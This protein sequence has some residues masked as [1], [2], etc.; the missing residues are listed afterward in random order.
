M[1][2]SER[3]DDDPAPQWISVK[4]LVLPA[5]LQI[6]TQ[7]RAAALE[8]LRRLLDDESLSPE[9]RSFIEKCLRSA[10]PPAP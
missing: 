9:A 6:P 2:S 10:A 3:D 1:A 8:H 4:G 7:D 5:A